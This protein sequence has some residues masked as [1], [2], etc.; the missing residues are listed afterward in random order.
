[1]TANST[2]L[3]T[4]GLASA[5]PKPLVYT[6]KEF[7]DILQIGWN[8]AYNLCHSG[9]LRV[10]RLGRSLRIPCAAVGECLNGIAA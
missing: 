2:H 10:I 6:V 9:D 5:V 7:A 4:I 1:M 8:Q 3:P